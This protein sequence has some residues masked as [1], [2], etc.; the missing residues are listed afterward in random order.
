MGKSTRK[1]LEAEAAA[2]KQIAD[3][4]ASKKNA[5]KKYRGVISGNDI[6]PKYVRR[7]SH[8][9]MN[10]FQ[11]WT[12]TGK[13]KRKDNQQLALIRYMF[14]KYP[15]PSFLEQVF[16][17]E[18]R[19][20]FDKYGSWYIAV[21]QGDSLY[22]TCTRDILTKKET[23]W[24]LQA[25]DKL[26]IK[27]AIW[28]AKGMAINQNMGDAYRLCQSPIVVRGSY[29]DEFWIDVH[30]FFMN[31]PTP[32]KEL[33]ELI[34][35]IQAAR[36]DNPDWT[37]KKRS[38][39]SIRRQSEKW[40]R[41]MAKLQKI[42]GGSWEGMQLPPWKTTT[43]R[44]DDNPQKNTQTEWFVHEITTGNE[45]AQEGNRM[46]HCVSGY[47]SRCM[48]GTCSIFSMRSST[49]MYDK[50]RHLTI[51]VARKSKA[52]V[53][54]RGLANRMPRGQEQAIMEQWARENNLTVRT[55]RGW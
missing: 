39:E 3:F 43:G 15:V 2:E 34:D 23:H 10:S 35:F 44:H 16:I 55:R 45:L 20:L 27:E 28:W 22:K 52:V 49:Q 51:E 48:D 8:R 19:N 29:M 5:G 41:D 40:H 17:S 32:M 7:F 24:L 47:K 14:A 31:N 38:L 26:S 21:A 42:G 37:I 46:R 1:K 9:Q 4:L 54:A 25:P 30:R 11:N 53:Q 33:Q 13:S 18:D 6:V 50:K 12:Y 36:V